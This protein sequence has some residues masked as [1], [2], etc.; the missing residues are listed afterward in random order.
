MGIKMENRAIIIAAALAASAA[1]F[2]ACAGS[3]HAAESEIVARVGDEVLTVDDLERLDADQRKVKMPTYLTKEELMEEW[4][5]SEV[6]YQ[7]AL[8]EAVDKE[9]E[10][11][12]RLDNSAKGIVI[13]RFWELNIYEKY[14]D[15]TDEA[16]LQWYEENKDQK[17]RAK[18][19]GVWLRRILLNTK[20][21]AEDVVRRL[22]AGED[23]VK[24]ASSESVAPEKL[25][26]GNQGYRRLEDV[27]PAYRAAVAKMK[28]G[29]TAGPFKLAD[30]YAIIK[31]EDRVE[32]GG[33]LKPEGI[34]MDLLRDRAKVARWRK[35]ADN[36][37]TDLVAAADIE[38]YP[39]RIREEAVDMA[40]GEEFP[41]GASAEAK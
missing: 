3:R 14:P 35:T 30:F 38:R 13:Q 20:E 7:Q 23:F 6:L 36:I 16:A 41:K 27:S 21:S 8:E 29:E 12:W 1:G 39:E 10:C 28:V 15:V 2:F 19:T 33:Y 4:V 25:E 40:L 37:G 11:T 31:L 26:G 5:R 17:Y 32:R 18:T 24:I 9:E 34:G 22:K